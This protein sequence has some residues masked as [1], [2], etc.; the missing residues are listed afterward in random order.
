MHK[1]LSALALGAGFAVATSASAQITSTAGVAVDNSAGGAALEGFVTSDIQ[2][3]FEGQYTGSQ[4]LL[5]LDSGSLFRAAF[6]DQA[7]GAPNPALF[8]V[9]GFETLQFDT[10]ILVGGIGSGPVDLDP[11]IVSPIFPGADS[12]TAG[13]LTLAQ[14]FNPAGGTVI[15]DQSDLAVFRATLSDDAQGTISFLSSA[16]SVIST[17][18]LLI[19]DGAIVAVPEPASAALVG[20]AGLSMLARRRKTA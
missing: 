17:E 9:P 11:T 15:A 8:V 5:A 13:P 2:I 16:N 18:E 12:T 14:A 1:I 6:G 19:V 10:S 7:G 20:L 4:I 3:S